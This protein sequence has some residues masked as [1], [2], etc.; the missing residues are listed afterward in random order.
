M[1]ESKK[2]ISRKEFKRSLFHKIVSGFVLIA[3]VV[4]ALL[5]LSIGFA[6]TSW[7]RSIAREKIIEN[8]NEN[9]N[10]EFYLKAVS[11]TFINSLKLN[12]FGIVVE[13][14]TVLSC[15]EASVK[16]SLQALLLKKIFVSKAAFRSP[17]IKILE[18]ANGNWDIN[19][20]FENK[21]RQSNS[22]IA[23]TSS[24]KEEKNDFPFVFELGDFE[25]TNG[26]FLVK[27]FNHQNS[28]SIYNQINYG[29]VHLRNFKLKI[30]GVGD[31]NK[32][33]FALFLKNLSFDDNLAHFKLKNAKGIFFVKP[34]LVEVRYL[35]VITDSSS[36]SLSTK[37]N[38]LNLFDKIVYSK[39]KN[40][41]ISLKLKLSPF[42]FSDLSSFIPSV[43]FLRGKIKGSLKGSGKY[44]DLKIDDLV[45]KRGYT[46][47]NLTGRL[48]NLEK[49]KDLYID[50]K[51][52]NSKI[53]YDEVL[54][55][56]AGLNLPK[57]RNVKLDSLAIHYYGEPT[58]FNAD[59]AT[60]IGKGNFKAK[61]FFDF[62][63]KETV[64]DFTINGEKLN[65]FPFID[66]MT[67]LNISVS[68]KGNGFSPEKMKNN[69]S[70]NLLDSRIDG[71]GISYLNFN[72][73]S[74]DG[75][76]DVALRGKVNGAKFTSHTHIGLLS[77][78][79]EY[80]F[81]SK[82]ENLDLSKIT[83]DSTL[84]SNLNFNVNFSSEALE[85]NNL[86]GE[87]N[88]RFDSSVF[89]G[90]EALSNTHWQMNFWG[91]TTQR[92]FDLESELFDASIEGN[93]N[94]H[95]LP[96]LIN[97]QGGRIAD[98]F[99]N[100]IQKQFY[101]DNIPDSTNNIELASNLPDLKLKYDFLIK[102]S[103]LAEKILNLKKLQ[104]NGY[105]KGSIENNKNRFSFINNTFLEHFVLLD[106]SHLYF[107][108]NF[109]FE[110][111]IQNLNSENNLKNLV[112]FAKVNADDF[113]G[114]KEITN[115]KFLLNLQ[116]NNLDFD[117]SATL[118]TNYSFGSKGK[119]TI[120]DSSD[121]FNF[122]D[123]AF[124]GNGEDWKNKS[125]FG[126]T[127]SKGVIKIDDFNLS[128]DS[129]QININGLYNEN[130]GNKISFNA[131]NIS[132][133]KVI[134][135]ISGNNQNEFEGRVNLHGKI[136]GEVSAPKIKGNITCSDFTFRKKNFGDLKFEENYSGA[137]SLLSLILVDK[138]GTERLSLKGAVPL[139]F[140]GEKNVPGK[141]VS[142]NFKANNFDL[143]AFAKFV[144][145][146]AN[147][148]GSLN[149][150]ISITGELKNPILNGFAKI[151]R[152]KFNVISTGMTYNLGADF[153]IKDNL[154]SIN[155][156]FIGTSGKSGFN[157]KLNFSGSFL[158]D[159]Y[160]FKEFSVSAMGELPLLDD[161]SKY[162]SPNLYGNLLIGTKGKLKLEYRNDRAFLTGNLVIKQ[163]N[164]TIA[165]ENSA[166]S[167][168]LSN[169]DYVYL[170]D[171]TKINQTELLLK[172]FLSKKLSEKEMKSISGENLFDYDLNLSIEN[173]ASLTFIFSKT[174]NQKL[175]VITNGSLLISNVE[176]NQAVQGTFNLLPGSR[177]E[178]FR[179]FDATGFVR[180]EGD[181]SNPY[182]NIEA[183]YEGNYATSS[184]GSGDV[185]KLVAVKIK[186]DGTLKDLA[187]KIATD[188]S[189]ISVYVGK[190][191]IDNNVADPQL[192]ASDAFSFILT[193]KFSRDLTSNERYQLSS[194]LASAATSMLGSVTAA[195]LNAQVG[196]LI[197]D[198][199]VKQSDYQTKITLKGRVGGFYYSVGGSQ[200]VLQD[201]STATWRLEYFFN[202][203]LSFRVERREPLTGYFSNT[204]MTDEVAIKYK[205]TF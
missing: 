170:V 204:Q 111:K 188:K 201:L 53:D 54:S 131:E 169:I 10:G 72:S 14:D 143:S 173:R 146:L 60:K 105:F 34:K 63:G 168:D 122:S 190:K 192:S 59:L 22:A 11:G 71:Y 98:L 144:P 162:S 102:K 145:S 125:P 196:D 123:L 47:L 26:N 42:C 64:Y 69:L 191:N 7:F 181:L 126:F 51:I 36:I 77:P 87:I 94:Y 186:L 158:L 171:S 58:K 103:D 39:F 17:T 8:V 45:L 104:L 78:S 66:Q 16:L 19:K 37:L 159:H 202:K 89:R 44:G 107:T 80:N 199:Q 197:N 95:E 49:P 91:D 27:D 136:F 137:T 43:S 74:V 128:S 84:T 68:A 115:P 106:N 82:I 193:G 205:V 48:K 195:F 24:I 75:V 200:L 179:T 62:T 73:H 148:S 55:L 96:I 41:P 156:M 2:N 140:F 18:D 157:G 13:G 4:I 182:F 160:K 174:V 141:N 121:I 28:D 198:I 112:L 185:E 135:S 65:L 61:S 114:E 166:S 189:N 108:N 35:D 153:R 99:I 81:S 194:E 127:A 129:A 32:N 119:V 120:T 183:V 180:F 86:E 138:K 1:S 118:D 85:K 134:N 40:Y 29:D 132:L 15:Q 161:K 79:R 93:F 117:F 76:S 155:K 184:A 20:L 50:A 165:N 167:V 164:I 178:F 46:D 187:K 109:Q 154:I 150:E 57:Y 151:G 100:E 5:L 175:Y 90:T 177:L 25:I 12:D 133:S 130:G 31:I 149:S 147:Q 56:L 97:K 113:Y 139:P 152:G 163:G 9:I 176:G 52:S 172:D 101:S 116:D 88:V 3:A 142:L 92:N 23:K 83:S 33:E 38:G 124:T 30:N 6:Q 110:T 21:A 203:N 70:L 67:S